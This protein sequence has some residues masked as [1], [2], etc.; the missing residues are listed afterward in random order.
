MADIFTKRRRS[1]IM[2]RIRFK[3]TTPEI[4]LRRDLFGRGFRFRKN[5]KV[6]G[7]STDIAFPGLRMA[8]FV[9]G[10][11]WRGHRKCGNGKTPK[12]NR[13]YWARKLRMN[14]LRD[15]RAVRRLGR[16]GWKAMVVWEC[17]ILKDLP[18]AVLRVV[19]FRS[20]LNSERVLTTLS[21]IG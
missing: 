8:V 19:A 13:A 18:R 6:A 5:Y 11:F 17:D 7:V 3:D 12:T 9:H 1:E 2:A 14:R 10:C 4:A 20:S 21:K 15:R 16:S